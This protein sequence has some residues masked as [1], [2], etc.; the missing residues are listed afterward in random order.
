MKKILTVR[1]MMK[2]R[3]VMTKMKTRVMTKKKT[4]I[5]TSR[6]PLNNSHLLQPPKVRV[7]DSLYDYIDRSQGDE[8]EEEKKEVA[9]AMM[10]GS[11]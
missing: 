7:W 9:M 2:V 11:G 6:I 3:T 4:V 1:V 5:K 8:E 10:R